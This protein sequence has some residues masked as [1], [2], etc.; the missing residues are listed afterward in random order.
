MDHFGDDYINYTR[1]KKENEKNFETFM[2]K[3]KKELNLGIKNKTSKN[4]IVDFK[5]YN[6]QNMYYFEFDYKIFY[7]KQNV[8]SDDFYKSEAFENGKLKFN[9][10]TFY[11]PVTWEPFQETNF[12]DFLI[13]D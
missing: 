4:K 10:D 2:K 3:F 8:L 12:D 7:L 11:H 1:L 6:H 13:L 9:I 5:I